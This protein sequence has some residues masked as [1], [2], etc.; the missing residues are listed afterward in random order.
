MVTN[1]FLA[2]VWHT[3]ASF[4]RQYEKK[5]DPQVLFEEAPPLAGK[6]GRGRGERDAYT[7]AGS[8]G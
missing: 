7:V 3:Y 8:A 6:S 5:Q 4:G 1:L 2:C